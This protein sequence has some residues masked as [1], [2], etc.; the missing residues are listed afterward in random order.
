MG[1]KEVGADDLSEKD[2]RSAK[3]RSRRISPLQPAD[4]PSEATRESV[5][6]I[7]FSLRDCNFD[8]RE[9]LPREKHKD[10]NNNFRWP[11]WLPKE[12]SLLAFA[13]RE[14]NTVAI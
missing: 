12:E 6:S 5:L 9:F 7:S 3:T 11:P 14:I 10:K 8:A 13:E 4:Q 2:L 1:G